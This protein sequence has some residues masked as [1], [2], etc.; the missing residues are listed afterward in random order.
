MTCPGHREEVI[1]NETMAILP[2]LS[3]GDAIIRN[4]S[5]AHQNSNAPGIVIDKP[6]SLVLWDG[7]VR[8]WLAETRIGVTSRKEVILSLSYEAA[9]DLGLGL[10]ESLRLD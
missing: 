6:C 5:I 3:G 8:C 4:T 9:L 2:T 7:E 1:E 10:S